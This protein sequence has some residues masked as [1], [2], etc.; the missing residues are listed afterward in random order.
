[1]SLMVYMFGLDDHE[2]CSMP[3]AKKLSTFDINTL[4]QP[5]VNNVVFIYEI[6]FH[7]WK[8]MIDLDIKVV[9]E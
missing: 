1:M 2:S 5:C 8:S 9:Y 7:Y 3:V 4:E 6:T